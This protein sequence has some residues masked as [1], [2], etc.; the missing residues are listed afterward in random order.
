MIVL[1]GVSKRFRTGGT[2]KTVFEGLDLQLPTDARLGILGGAQSG[3]ST[4]A[5][6]LAGLEEPSSGRIH[7]YAEVS[8]PIGYSRAL[9]PNMS[10]RE[11]VQHAARLYG[12]DPAEVLD[13]VARTTDI[14]PMLEEPLRRFPH[15]DRAMLAHALGYALPFDTYLIDEFVAVGPPRF[16]ERCFK[17]LDARCQESGLILVTMY[18]RKVREHCDRVGV[19]AQGKL[20]LFDRLQEGIDYFERLEVVGA[21]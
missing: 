7:R 5:H 17:M 12:A 6:L 18:P 11:N 20:T 3:K 19:I 14:G 21:S 16:R 8:F 4:L 10:G 1:D 13:L 2:S 15:A 9:R